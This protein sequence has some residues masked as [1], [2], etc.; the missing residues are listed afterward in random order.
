VSPEPTVRGNDV[1]FAAHAVVLSFLT[2][3]MF[4]ES[5]WGFKQKTGQ[6]VSRGVVGI[7]VGCIIGVLWTAWMVWYGGGIGGVRAWM[8]IDVVYDNLVDCLC[9]LTRVAG[10][11][12]GLCKAFH[13]D[14]QIYAPG[15]DKLQTEIDG[16]MEHRA[17]PA[18]PC[19][20]RALHRS[21]CH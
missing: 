7:G 4:W 2:W 17:N 12:L 11:R 5:A 19:R 8:E 16:R 20:W 14:C 3:T 21:A 6:R 13:H 10:L 18:R 1:V 15:L 9:M